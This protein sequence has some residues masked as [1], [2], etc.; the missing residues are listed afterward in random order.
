MEEKVIELEQSVEALEEQVQILEAKLSMRELKDEII[1]HVHYLQ[2]E[3]LIKAMHNVLF[4][5]DD[6]ILK[7][8]IIGRVLIEK[9]IEVLNN[10]IKVYDEAKPI[11]PGS[12]G[13]QGNQ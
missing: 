11:I 8:K 9:D 7:E 4:E 13:G 2:S 10:V 12:G 5:S 6:I 1:A 3:S